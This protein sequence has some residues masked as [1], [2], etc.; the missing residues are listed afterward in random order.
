MIVVFDSSCFYCVV[1][2]VVV[3]PP[4]PKYKLHGFTYI[5]RICLMFVERIGL[6]H[7]ARLLVSSVPFCTVHL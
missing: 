5:F 7:R 6:K 2:V 3:P 1:V 4:P